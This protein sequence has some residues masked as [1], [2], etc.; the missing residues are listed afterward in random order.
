MSESKRRAELRAAANRE[1]TI[2]HIGKEGI[3]ENLL[4]QIDAA[5]NAREL[6]K[7]RVLET[8]MLTPRQ[9]SEYICGELGA[10]P[11]QCIGSKFVIYRENPEKAQKRAMAAAAESAA[12][13]APRESAKRG[14]SRGKSDSKGGSCAS[15]GCAAK[16]GCGTRQNREPSRS[17]GGR[18]SRS[19]N[20]NAAAKKRKFPK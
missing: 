17:G 10:M 18:G 1:D 12:R 4:K 3:T 11:V 13:Y 14:A 8:A 16:G 9:A 7:C 5:L 2:V 15:R 20:A 19:R 6:I